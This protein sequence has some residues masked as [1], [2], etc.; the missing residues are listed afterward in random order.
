MNAVNLQTITVSG[1]EDDRI[2]KFSVAFSTESSALL[3][4]VIKL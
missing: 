3:L 1:I 4:R 2:E